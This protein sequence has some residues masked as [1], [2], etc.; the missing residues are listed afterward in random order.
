[1]KN[2]I[3]NIFG[4]IALV[5][6]VGFVV[7]A[8]DKNNSSDSAATTSASGQLSGTYVDESGEVS[9]TFS[10]NKMIMGHG[11]HDHEYTFEIK[12]GKLIATSEHGATESGFS[13]EGD[14]LT[15]VRDD[16]TLVLTKQ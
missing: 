15:L 14:K 16:Q 10:G 4:I 3:K 12:D 5:A 1:M 13:L 6:V 8:C 11:D 7:V 9:Y 2:A